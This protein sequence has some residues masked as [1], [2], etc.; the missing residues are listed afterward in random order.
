[1]QDL[2]EKVKLGQ[3]GY[4]V[5]ASNLTVSTATKLHQGMYNCVKPGDADTGD[6]IIRSFNITLTGETSTLYYGTFLLVCVT[7]NNLEI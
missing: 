6:T 3:L 4:S 5:Y 1:M 2:S 7:Q